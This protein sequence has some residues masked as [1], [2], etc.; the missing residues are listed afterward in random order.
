MAI[1]YRGTDGRKLD[2][3][4]LVEAING[5]DQ[6]TIRLMRAALADAFPDVCW[7]LNGRG[8]L[9]ADIVSEGYRP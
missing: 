6:P 5:Q 4:R 2:I 1:R 8:E 3:D 7:T 9:H